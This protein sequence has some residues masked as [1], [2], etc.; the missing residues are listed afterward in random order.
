M[1]LVFIQRFIYGSFLFFF[2]VKNTA[3][4]VLAV[5]SVHSNLDTHVLNSFLTSLT[6]S[7]DITTPYVILYLRIGTCY[8]VSEIRSQCWCEILSCMF[9]SDI[10][11]LRSKKDPIAKSI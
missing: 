2:L 6:A 4:L 9:H 5:V 7:S 8:M 3:N 10:L 11:H 1:I